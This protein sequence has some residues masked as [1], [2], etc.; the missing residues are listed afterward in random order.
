[1]TIDY[2]KYQQYYKDIAHQIFDTA[3]PSGYNNDIQRLI[4]QLSQDNGVQC[5]TTNKGGMVIN[6]AGASSDKTLGLSA[7]ID[8]LGLMVRS[9]NS[10]GTL[11]FVRIG[12]AQLE[13]LDGEY[14]QILTRN[15]KKY[16][17]TILCS[18]PSSHVYDDAGKKRSEDNMIIRIDENVS[19][20]DDVLALGIAVGD[21]V[22]YDAKTIFTDSGYLKSRFID[23]KASVCCILTIL[24]I[25]QDYNIQ[26]PHNVAILFSVYEE[27][28]HGAS[29]VP[30]G[31]SS[32]LAV[33]MGCI[34][35]DLSCNEKQ[36]SICAKDSS[37][38]YDYN[39]TTQLINMAK[40]NNID[41][42]VDVYPHYSSDVSAMYRAGHDVPGALIGTGVHA[43]HGMER[44][45]MD[46]IFN[47]IKLIMLYLGVNL[48]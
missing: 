7:H 39:F 9:I 3:S 22:A 1:M 23:D 6:V 24:R 36:V 46:G 26:L 32:M 48:K 47:T 21:Y 44:T 43:S 34:G 16:T 27:V 18:S 38:P 30:Q 33:D 5:T 42:A 19:N 14:C 28:G 4:I 12:G 10:D 25:I 11:R 17:G 2:N 8:T 15:G 35:S 40:D 41:Y 45:H 13:T 29:C 31:L 20:K 37:G